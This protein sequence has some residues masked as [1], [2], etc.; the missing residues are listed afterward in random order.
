MVNEVEPNAL[1]PH[2]W[3]WCR[4]VRCSDHPA[5]SVLESAGSSSEARTSSKDA[6]ARLPV[7]LLF[8]GC[9]R[10]GH[11]ARANGSVSGDTPEHYTPAGGLVNHHGE[12]GRVELTIPVTRHR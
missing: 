9:S 2:W 6:S 5:G 4:A 7:H 11:G 10:D 8:R 12:G 1:G 3:Q